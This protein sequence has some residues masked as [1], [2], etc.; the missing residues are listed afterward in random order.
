MLNKLSS[1]VVTTIVGMAR[2]QKPTA[3]EVKSNHT[4]V[5]GRGIPN[6]KITVILP[7]GTDHV[8]YVST[9]GDYRIMIPKQEA[10]SRITVIQ[11]T[12][13]RLDSEPLYIDVV[14]AIPAP[15]PTINEMDTDDTKVT[16]KGVPNSNVFVK[17][18]GKMERF[19]T[20]NGNG[21]WE[22]DTGLLDG[23]QEIIAHQELP[24]RP[25]SE[26]I[27]IKV[28]QLPAFRKP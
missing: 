16:G 4:E 8:G 18:P 2:S 26:E 6:S 28:K 23:G 17:I 24:D 22:L 1:D 7:N 12:P 10:N 3:N 13:R 15:N 14:R 27:K 5:T 19:V 20:V 9:E 25:N 11:K 21:D